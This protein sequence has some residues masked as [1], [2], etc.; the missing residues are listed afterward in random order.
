MEGEN[1]SVTVSENRPQWKNRRRHSEA[2][3][4]KACLAFLALPQ[5]SVISRGPLYPSSL[6]VHGPV[7]P[8]F[9]FQ[10]S[11]PEE[12]AL[13][14][15]KAAVCCLF[16]CL[17]TTTAHTQTAPKVVFTGDNFMNAWQQTTQF[18]ANKNW[19]GAGIQV[20][21]PLG[22]G[23]SAVEADFQAAAIAGQVHQQLERRDRGGYDDCFQRKTNAA[24]DSEPFAKM[25]SAQ[26]L[27][28]LSTGLPTPSRAIHVCWLMTRWRYSC[29]K[30]GFGSRD[31]TFSQQG[32]R[33]GRSCGCQ[34]SSGER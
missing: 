26:K 7:T 29:S 24:K 11:L 12:A 27:P 5:A 28:R 18:T 8:G 31:H 10:S 17:L 32:N 16:S 33:A 21:G 34:S 9:L 4:L 1:L 22:P 23:S 30:C 2:P 13:P 14:M 20:Q 6:T 15:N 3:S 25:P 19:I